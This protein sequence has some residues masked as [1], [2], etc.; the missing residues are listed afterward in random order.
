MNHKIREDVQDSNA[1][2][3]LVAII[4]IVFYGSLTQAHAELVIHNGS[5][6]Q[7]TASQVIEYQ[8]ATIINGQQP[9]IVIYSYW[10][11]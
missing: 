2:P 9:S 5:S 10:I 11:N 6:Q 7:I 3:W 4:A 8:T 1:Y